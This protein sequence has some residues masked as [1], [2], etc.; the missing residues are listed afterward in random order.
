MPGRDRATASV[1]HVTATWLALRLVGIG[2]PRPRDLHGLSAAVEYMVDDRIH[3]LRG[4]LV[5]EAGG[6]S[7]CSV[8]FVFRSGAQFLGR[9]EHLRT[10]LSAPIVITADQT[11]QKFRGRTVNVSEGGMLV[12]DLDGGLPEPGSRLKF[13]LAPRNSRDTILGTG[14]VTRANSSRGSLALNFDHL[15]REAA[16]ALA[17]L[18]FEHQH[19]SRGR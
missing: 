12:E 13:A 1:T 9:R 2:A 17:R 8:R 19:G 5:E 15:T 3:R 4:D 11:G 16:D 18:V 7:S 10:A 14:I 6:S